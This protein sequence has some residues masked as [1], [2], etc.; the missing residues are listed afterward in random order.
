MY[1]SAQVSVEAGRSAPG[2]NVTPKK[3]QASVR[4]AFPG[5]IV[6]EGSVSGEGLGWRGSVEGSEEETEAFVW[7]EL[8]GRSVSLAGLAAHLP[9]IWPAAELEPEHQGAVGHCV[10]IFALCQE[11]DT[12]K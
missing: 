1:D 11:E 12:Q 5:Q 2:L 10:H 7:G 8:G 3:D 4:Q 9:E 6:P